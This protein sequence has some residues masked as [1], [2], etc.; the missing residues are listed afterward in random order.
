MRS[1][2]ESSKKSLAIVDSD[3]NFHTWLDGDTSDLL[4]NIGRSM[5][6]DQTLVDAHFEAIPSVGTLT[7]GSLTGGNLQFLGRKAN[8]ST[9][10]ELLVQ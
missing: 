2:T 6:V 8:G 5:Q 4:D 3:I 9:N 7:T 10:M 1:K